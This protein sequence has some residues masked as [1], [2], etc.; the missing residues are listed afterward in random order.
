MTFPEQAALSTMEAE[1]DV[2]VV[3]AGPAGATAALV[4]ARSGFR[5]ALIESTR[6]ERSRPGETLP[7]PARMLLARLGVWDAFSTLGSLPS[8]GNRSIWGGPEIA[9]SSFIFHPYG[10][11]WHVDRQ[12]F[13]AMLASTAADAGAEVLY[14][15][16][17]V[18]CSAPDADRWHIGLRGESGEA[19]T[20]AARAIVDATGRTARIARRLGATRQLADHLVG[21]AV[22]YAGP[23]R[24]DGFTLVEAAS[25]G[26]WYSAPVPPDRLVVMFM[27]DAD[28]HRS[29]RLTE[30]DR[31][32]HLLAEAPH[33]M[34]RVE[35]CRPIAQPAFFAAV[36]HR[37]RRN[38][39][40]GCWLACGDAA[41]GVDPLSSSGIV[42]AIRT[43]EGAGQAIGNWLLGRTDVAGAYERILDA[44]FEEYMAERSGYYALET[45]WPHSTFWNRR[46]TI[47][48]A[49]RQ[50]P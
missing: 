42:R 28:I 47:D 44:E 4:L 46:R 27:S 3:G 1:Y 34:E 21:A 41:I 45:R 11:G 31:W 17:V 20:M 5:V 25:S 2:A 33:T 7:P 16:S 26:W 8:H 6:Y 50:Q 37:L 39:A 38:G 43:G 9:E 30:G 24:E 10:E 35:G 48:A 15:M 49:M 12:R 22:H 32:E 40:R 23:L 19:G 18:D 36:S 29:L 13:D 14:G